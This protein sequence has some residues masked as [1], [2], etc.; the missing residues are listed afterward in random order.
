MRTALP[1]IHLAP[2]DRLYLYSDGLTDAMNAT[3]QRFGDARL[4]E[5]ITGTRHMPLR[6]GIDSLLAQIVQ[7]QGGDRPQDDISVL[8]L[9]IAAKY[10]L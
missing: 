7:W 2:G 1:V 5:A 9:E 8:A 3:G 4:V 10:K 6:E